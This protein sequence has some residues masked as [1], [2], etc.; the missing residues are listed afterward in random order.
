[1]TGKVKLISAGGGSVSLATPSTGS[2]RTVTLPDADLTIPAT[3]SSG[4]LT[5]QG[6]ILYRDGSGLQRLPK[7]T[8]GHY[9]KQG[10]SNA[11]EWAAVAAGGLTEF[12]S[13]RLTTMFGGDE[14]PLT[15]NLE[16]ED[17][18]STS[19]K[20]GT[21]MSVSSGIW[22]FPSTGYWRI[23]FTALV[24]N[25]SG[26]DTDYYISIWTTQNA[27]AG[28]PTW[29]EVTRCYSIGL[30]NYYN[31][32]TSTYNLDVTSTT[33]V[34]IKLDVETSTHHTQTYGNTGYTQTGVRFYKIADT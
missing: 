33:D 32:V 15:N 18:G 3:N 34:K 10:T 9:L 2:N 16:R 5:T 14:K 31:V 17:T 26:S 25:V 20:L 8:N 23:E 28:S 11:P 12:D 6:D 21:G 24:R 13:W 19:Y 29:V 4:T 27:S 7:G 1:M 30:L 22:T